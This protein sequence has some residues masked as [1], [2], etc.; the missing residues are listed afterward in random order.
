MGLFVKNHAYGG[1]DGP[2]IWMD[3]RGTPEPIYGTC[4]AGDKKAIISYLNNLDYDGPA[5]WASYE[6]GS[7]KS[8]QPIPEKVAIRE[9][10][11]R[12]EAYDKY[13]AEGN[14]RMAR[15]YLPEM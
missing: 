5:I 4:V 13:M 8:F 7:E 9:E 1:V 10:K 3:S 15:L 6:S 12:Q 11:I 14:E 2:W